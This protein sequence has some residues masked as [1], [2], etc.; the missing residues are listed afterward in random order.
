M[1]GNGVSVC[2]KRIEICAFG[3]TVGIE[4]DV[5]IARRQLIINKRPDEV[6]GKG[7][8]PESDV[9]SRRDGEVDKRHGVE[10]VRI[11]LIEQE[12]GGR[13]HLRELDRA[14]RRGIR[15]PEPLFDGVPGD[16]DDGLTDGC[17]DVHA[18]AGIVCIGGAACDDPGGLRVGLRVPDG[19]A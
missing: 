8:H 9:C 17:A 18:M 14:G 19:T 1:L 16:P 13:S 4:A 15:M 10:R 5:I 12:P 2:F 7:I 6:T 3:H 11:V